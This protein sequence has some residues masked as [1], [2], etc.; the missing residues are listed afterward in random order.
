MFFLF[1]SH[2]GCED[3]MSLCQDNFRGKRTRLSVAIATQLD[4]YIITFT[5]PSTQPPSLSLLPTSLPLPNLPP[6][7]PRVSLSQMKE[8]SVVHCT[9]LLSCQ[10]TLSHICGGLMEWVD[11]MQSQLYWSLISLW[12]FLTLYASELSCIS[13]WGQTKGWYAP[14]SYDCMT[15]SVHIIVRITKIGLQIH[16][17]ENISPTKVCICI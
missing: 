10:M 2:S 7:S 15:N 17:L 5:S 13:N 4:V 14:F 9:V 16:L 11:L 12:M 8:L 3:G 1:S 6:F